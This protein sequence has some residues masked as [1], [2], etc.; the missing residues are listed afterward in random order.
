LSSDASSAEIPS[1]VLLLTGLLRL[2]SAPLMLREVIELIAAVVGA[3]EMQQFAPALS[4]SDAD[5]RAEARFLFVRDFLAK[6]SGRNILLL[7]KHLAHLELSE[8]TRTTLMRSLLFIATTPASVAASI[9]ASLAP[10]PAAL[11]R[12]ILITQPEK[13]SEQILPPIQ[14]AARDATPEQAQRR[15]ENEQQ[16]RVQLRLIRELMATLQVCQA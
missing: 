10:S 5:A 15:V 16:R 8:H 6:S 14:L 3:T 2:G 13:W 11:A 9:A 1:C 12:R 4:S 7:S